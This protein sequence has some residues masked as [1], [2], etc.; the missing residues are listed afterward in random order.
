MGVCKSLDV[1]M[2]LHS[3]RAVPPEVRVCGEEF[4]VGEGLCEE[5]EGYDIPI[6]LQG[7]GVTAVAELE[8]PLLDALEAVGG[9]GVS[10]VVVRLAAGEGDGHSGD[11]VATRL[12]VLQRVWD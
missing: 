7:L 10:A 6:S 5:V 3:P 11:L 12:G 9:Q 8:L 2:M 1:T 4:V